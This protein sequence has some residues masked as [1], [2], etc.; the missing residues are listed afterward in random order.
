MN[1]ESSRVPAVILAA[2]ASTRLGRPKQLLRPSLFHGLS[3]LEQAVQFARDAGA[4]PVFV[5]LGANV[6]QIV[7]ECS[8]DG[9]TVLRNVDWSTGMAA[10]LRCGISAVEDQ[11]VGCD[12]VLLMVC[13]QPKLSSAH[14]RQLLEAHTHQPE[15]IVASR[16]VGSSGVPA[17]VPRTMFPALMLLRGEQGARA[18]FQE[19]GVIEIDFPGGELDIDSPEDLEHFA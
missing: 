10:S 1:I 7:H 16:Y 5:V 2:G 9:A 14:L 17:I 15:A 3:L 11:C 13:D 12:G 19:N 18:I 6:E 8:F 4:S